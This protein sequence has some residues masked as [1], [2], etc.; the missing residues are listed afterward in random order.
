MAK[1]T[2]LPVGRAHP[3]IKESRGAATDIMNFYVTSASSAY[4]K[5]SIDS[6][7]SRF[8]DIPVY[9]SNQ[10]FIPRSAPEDKRTGYTANV[11]PQIYYN[12]TLDEFDNPSMKE[13][14]AQ[15]YV[16]MTTTQFQ[17]YQLPDG[18]EEFPVKVADQTSAFTQ[19]AY[20]HNPLEKDV[21]DLFID[22]KLRAP[23]DTVNKHRTRL[24]K[25]NC[26][27]PIPGEN[28]DHGPNYMS[29]EFRARFDLDKN[30]RDV[31]RKINGE[32]GPKETSGFVEN[33]IVTD[34][35]TE[36]KGERWMMDEKRPTGVTVNQDKYPD[37][38]YPK[39]DDITLPNISN[40]DGTQN[41]NYTKWYTQSDVNPN[42]N[43]QAKFNNTEFKTNFYQKPFQN[44]QPKV[45]EDKG[46]SHQGPKELGGQSKCER[47]FV[48]TMDDPR[49][50]TSSYSIDHYAMNPR[51]KD[52]EGYV[53]G[54][55]NKGEMDNGYF[56]NVKTHHDK[57]NAL[58][59]GAQLYAMDSYQS[60]SL[61][62]NDRFAADGTHGHK[63]ASSNH[64]SVTFAVDNNAHSAKLN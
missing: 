45:A 27:D 42:R 56:K 10:V 62:A 20:N 63:L 34:A 24:D 43:D 26:K 15:N 30:L 33:K 55:V 12:K 44:P 60:R 8:K 1:A 39:N 23:F 38:A 3:H 51:G 47:G 5:P 14:L 13:L 29:T 46:T 11:R 17:A 25:T 21:H 7:K 59:T 54:G 6:N 48:Q 40:V 35:L 61:R 52:R 50:F 2:P 31:P 32:T 18:M 49:R 64:P 4:T 28:H 9:S 16:P 57:T 37:F 53:A 58:N 22:S 41:T 19:T 36:L